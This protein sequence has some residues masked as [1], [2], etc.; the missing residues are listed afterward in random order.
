MGV[1][2]IVC[3]RGGELWN[4]VVGGGRWVVVGWSRVVDVVVFGE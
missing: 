3:E 4:G 2:V 1:G